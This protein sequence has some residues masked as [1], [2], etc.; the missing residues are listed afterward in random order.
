M[1]SSC[2]FS[3][4]LKKDKEGLLGDLMWSLLHQAG[5]SIYLCNTLERSP[6]DLRLDCDSSPYQC[7][8]ACASRPWMC[9]LVTTTALYETTLGVFFIQVSRWTEFEVEYSLRV[10]VIPYFPQSKVN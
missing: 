8:G 4:F 5:S 9:R 3:I 1:K 2:L 7:Q 10:G 6:L